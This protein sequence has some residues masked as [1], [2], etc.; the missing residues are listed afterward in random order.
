[1]VGGGRRGLRAAPRLD[2]D[3]AGGDG[4][5]GEQRVGR[6]IGRSH[7]NTPAKS[8]NGWKRGWNRT[9]SRASHF[10]EAGGWCTPGGSG[11]SL[12]CIT[13]R[14]TGQAE[15]LHVPGI[16]LIGPAVGGVPDARVA[17]LLE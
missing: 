4:E 13:R 6:E 7:G 11:K 16:A 14:R 5:G 12:Q 3:R 8:T 15:L 9:R 17:F 10:S 1:H 2:D